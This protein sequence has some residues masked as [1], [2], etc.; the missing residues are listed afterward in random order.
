MDICVDNINYELMLSSIRE[1]KNLLNVRD[2]SIFF[3]LDN[4]GVICSVISTNV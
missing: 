4:L 3:I 1:F 2:M